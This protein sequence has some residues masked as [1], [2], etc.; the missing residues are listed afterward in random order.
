MKKYLLLALVL[1]CEARVFFQ[2]H[3]VPERLYKTESAIIDGVAV[4]DGHVFVGYDHY[5]SSSGGLG[6]GKL[7]KVNNDGTVSEREFLPKED[8]WVS[9]VRIVQDGD[10]LVAVYLAKGNTTE[11]YM[12][13][14]D[15]NLDEIDGPVLV[16]AV[17]QEPG[18][19]YK[20]HD[21]YRNSDGTFVFGLTDYDNNS[22][23]HKEYDIIKM[24]SSGDI[25]AEQPL[26]SAEYGSPN[27]LHALTFRPNVSGYYYVGEGNAG[28]RPY[29]LTALDHELNIVSETT[30]VTMDFSPNM[31]GCFNGPDGNIYAL[32]MVIWPAFNG[33][34]RHYGDLTIY[35]MDAEMNQVSCK[36]ADSNGD[37][38]MVD[39]P[40][41]SQ[42]LCFPDEETILSVGTL[43]I[44]AG[45][46][47]QYP[48]WGL[49]I[50]KS[51]L[52]LNI[53]NE[54]YYI[55][56]EY[57][58][59]TYG[60]YA[61]QDGGCLVVTNL[62][63]RNSGNDSKYEFAILKFPAEAFL[64]IDEAHD[65]GFAVAVA[66]PNPGGNTLNIRTALTGSHVELYDTGGRLVGRQDITGAVTTMSTEGLPSGVYVWKVIKDGS[67]AES[68][69][70]VKE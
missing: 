29:L 52:D 12:S 61:C 25:L 49:Y 47:L 43:D 38:D 14:F 54:L 28:N 10:D 68:G 50:G 36:V 37:K 33:N 66:Y 40:A 64:G 46:G 55:D 17:G 48:C 16:K 8:S 18:H 21:L 15:E 59:D 9:S 6:Y 67:E 24:S 30:A 1:L 57:A 7:Y 35:K 3:V 69:K 70:W 60:V 2:E 22:I 27:T 41:I 44:S 62:R 13:R 53:L 63:E 20:V 34:P 42:A 4:G 11:L 65:A 5:N 19:S 31:L 51:T 39:W 58:M 23:C 32:A 26:S 56:E 45:L